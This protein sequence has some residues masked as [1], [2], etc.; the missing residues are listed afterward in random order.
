MVEDLVYTSTGKVDKK[1]LNKMAV[2]TLS[3]REPSDLSA[4]SS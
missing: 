4:G 3:L 2:S 1:R